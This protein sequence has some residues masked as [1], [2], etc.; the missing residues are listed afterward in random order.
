MDSIIYKL[1][2]D[3]LPIC[4]EYSL[5]IDALDNPDVK[6]EPVNFG[7]QTYI[8]K[9]ITIM[10]ESKLAVKL[11]SLQRPVINLKRKP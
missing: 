4:I 5:L 8:I 11:I 10:D 7:A 2:S 3:N 9:R 1:K 6:R